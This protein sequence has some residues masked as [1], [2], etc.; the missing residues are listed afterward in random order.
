MRIN[1]ALALI[2]CASCLSSC[3]KSNTIK[4]AN[5]MPPIVHVAHLP[6][7]WYPQQADVLSQ[8]LSHYFNLAK[9][10]FSVA[11]DASSVRALIVPHAG[12]YFSGLCAATVY[13]TLFDGIQK[14]KNIKRVIILCPSHTTF[15]KG[16]AL[17]RFNVY[18][19]ALGDVTI[20]KEALDMLAV[21]HSFKG[22]SRAHE[23]E[24]AIEIQL[25]FLQ[26]T[27][28]DFTLV[29]LIIGHVTDEDIG[30]IIHGLTKIIDK[31]TLVVI[32][33]DFIHHGPSYEYD[34]FDRNIIHNIRYFDSLAVNSIC[35]QD[36]RGFERVLKDTGATICGQNPIKILLGLINKQVIDGVNAR[37]TCYYTAAHMHKARQTDQ[38]IN[39]SALLQDPCDKDARENVS[40]VGM[41]LST[42]GYHEL[43]KEDL[44]TGYEKKS[45]LALA[46]R[47]IANAFIDKKE[48]LP[49]HLL[50]PVVSF[51]MQQPIGAF[52]TLNTKK[53]DLRGCIGNIV[54]NAPIFQTVMRMAV[55]AAFEDTRFAP[56][57][58]H[59]LDDIVI[60]ITLLTPPVKVESY[61]DI[62]IGKHGVILN[63][64]ND[65]GA[66][67]ASSV[68]LPQVPP[69]YKWSVE[70]MLEQLSL[71]AGL[72]RD[73]WKSKCSFEV[74][75]G[76]EIKE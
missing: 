76:H 52:V 55:A 8:E 7:G 1:S 49:D 42:Q 69:A 4:A 10:H 47:T 25:P 48:R 28:D 66:I 70:T 20:D 60:D 6:A 16:C 21:G 74:F 45:L 34:V 9:E 12:M 15:L 30:D 50:Y 46:R 43:N 2:V 26:K 11:A 27:I 37:L 39:V 72:A 59:E 31:D 24:H 18:R 57:K 13:Q 73:A 62:T 68:F 58:K 22:D 40:Y 67:I 64:L 71:K 5:K 19:T 17:P 44:I 75:E 63:K 51:G 23:Q 65:A 56:L 32:S 38:K 3:N 29:P 54:T 14:N 35:A 61:K 53:G 36:Y 41:V 33:T